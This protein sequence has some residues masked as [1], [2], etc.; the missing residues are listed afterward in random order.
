MSNEE[1]ITKKKSGGKTFGIRH[2]ALIEIICFFIILLFIAWLFGVKYNFFNISPHPFWIVVV[3]ISSQYGTI[4]GLL[5]AL[6]ATAVFLF[7]PLPPPTILQ[8]KFEH[9]FFI[10]KLP[11]LW[12][13]AAVILGE[14]RMKHLREMNKL[15]KIADE[16]AERERIVADSY[17][18][19]KKMKERLEMRVASEMQTS[20][21]VITA[22]K[23][24]DEQRKE[25]ILQGA[26]NLIKALVAPDKFSIYLLEDSKLKRITSWGWQSN[27][28]YAEYFSAES[29]LFQEVII[30][31]R[32]VAITTSDLSVL[33]SEG[34]LAAPILFLSEGKNPHVIGMIKVEQIPFLRIRTA[35]IEALSEIGEWIGKPMQKWMK[36]YE[37]STVG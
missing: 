22:F 28:Q 34:L 13:I 5:A 1:E 18:S 15:K 29:P 19:L 33:G 20:L 9:F 16:A 12:F 24:L 3:L 14:L 10:F 7:G 36:L 2:S 4:E 32:T 6:A 27:E 11:I 30:R 23:Q 35:T 17:N 26:C 37:K 25:S 31:K 8:D 21:M